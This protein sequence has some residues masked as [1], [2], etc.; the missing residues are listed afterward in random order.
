MNVKKK[1]KKKN[2][3]VNCTVSLL[4]AIL[5]FPYC[6]FLQEEMKTEKVKTIAL[7]VW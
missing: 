7:N 1:K 6:L 5:D 2:Y 3:S 4:N